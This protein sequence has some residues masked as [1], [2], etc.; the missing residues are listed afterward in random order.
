[1]VFSFQRQ[2]KEPLQSFTEGYVL[3][4]WVQTCHFQPKPKGYPSHRQWSR[5]FISLFPSSCI[6]WVCKAVRHLLSKVKNSWAISGLASMEEKV[7]LP[8]PPPSSKIR[9]LLETPPLYPL[10]PRSWD[11]VNKVALPRGHARGPAVLPTEQRPA[12]CARRPPQPAQQLQWPRPSAPHHRQPG[13]G[14]LQPHGA[15]ACCGDPEEA[16]KKGKPFSVMFLSSPEEACSCQFNVDEGSAK[17]EGPA[18]G[19]S[20]F[21]LWFSSQGSWPF[22]MV[23]QSRR[24]FTDNSKQLVSSL[25]DCRSWPTGLHLLLI[26][27]PLPPEWAWHWLR[28]Y[29]R[30]C[31]EN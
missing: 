10:K 2:E 31:I 27:R 13:A 26:L 22:I 6:C 16:R 25:R 11:V 23:C 29:M 9:G 15:P 21:S 4:I 17:I 20:C 14:H 19:Y 24:E 1:M 30:Q 8:F 28:K 3:R 7:F 5:P 12:A 18:D